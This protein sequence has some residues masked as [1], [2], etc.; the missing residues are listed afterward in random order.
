MLSFWS[1]AG[2]TVSQISTRGELEGVGEGDDLQVCVFD[3]PVFLQSRICS[4]AQVICLFLL[5]HTRRGEVNEWFFL[6]QA[7]HQVDT[8]IRRIRTVRRGKF[9]ILYN[10][11]DTSPAVP[12]PPSRFVTVLSI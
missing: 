2:S 12:L 3:S 4:F 5:P 10:S 8:R 7:R 6:N 1:I 9:A 11:V